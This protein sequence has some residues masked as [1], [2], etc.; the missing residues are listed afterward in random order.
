MLLYIYVH[1]CNYTGKGNTKFLSLHPLPFTKDTLSAEALTLS[2]ANM[3]DISKYLGIY[4]YAY[5]TTGS[6]STQWDMI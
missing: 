3:H 5:T 1:T 4:A 6:N 2:T